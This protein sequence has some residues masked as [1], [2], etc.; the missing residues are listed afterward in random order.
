MIEG[1]LRDKV[2]EMLGFLPLLFVSTVYNDYIKETV[3]LIYYEKEATMKKFV[4][5]VLALLFTLSFLA[6]M[7]MSQEKEIGHTKS[8]MKTAT[9]KVIGVDP[10]G[11]GIAIT[12]RAAGDDYDVGT[13]VD[14]STKITVR[15]K[16]ATLQNIQVGDTVTIRYWKS[17]DLYAKEITKK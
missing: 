13:I 4:L 8:E 7:A 1:E 6:E 5:I 15:G 9:G 14:N 3:V 10:Q 17:D 16:P 12:M 2:Q 11:G